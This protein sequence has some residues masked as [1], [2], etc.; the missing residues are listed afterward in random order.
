MNRLKVIRKTRPTTLTERLITYGLT[1]AS[2]SLSTNVFPFSSLSSETAKYVSNQTTIESLSLTLPLIVFQHNS[3][4]AL[5]LADILSTCFGSTGIKSLI[6]KGSDLRCFGR[7]DAKYVNNREM[8][9]CV[10]RVESRVFYA[11]KIILVNASK[12]F[13]SMLSTNNYSNCDDNSN[14]SQTLN[15]IMTPIVIDNIR[16][17]IFLVNNISYTFLKI[18]NNSLDIS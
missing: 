15:T 11:H 16:Y 9:D 7:I 6:K 10:F 14:G 18:W 8:S 3:T 13:Q 1:T 5:L 4:T 12:R 17:D 2:H